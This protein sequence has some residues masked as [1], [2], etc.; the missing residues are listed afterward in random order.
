MGFFDYVNELYSSIAIQ[1]ASADV[2]DDMKHASGDF[3]DGK[4]QRS[5]GVGTAEHDRGAT[6]KGGASLD[7]PAAGTDEESDAEAKENKKDAKK[8]DGESAPGHK[9]GDGGEKS[10]QVG[11][12]RAGPHGGPVTAAKD[13]GDDEEE[14]E[15]GG[16][17]EEEEEEEDEPVDP[18]PKFVEG[19]H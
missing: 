13:D 5:G 9:P 14:E 3:N 4:D 1:S 12:D 8:S 15:S 2:Q 10:G 16:D 11:P 17:D 6:T 19:E 18:M 7:S